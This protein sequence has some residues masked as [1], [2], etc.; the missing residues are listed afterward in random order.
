MCFIITPMTSNSRG[1]VR[2]IQPG[3]AY[4][5]QVVGVP[6]GY[7]YDGDAEV[8]LD[9]DGGITKFLITKQ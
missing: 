6:A 5:I 1:I 8:Y 3:F 7:S 2:F 9:A 4:H